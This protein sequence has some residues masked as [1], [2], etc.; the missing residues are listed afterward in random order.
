MDKSMRNR[1]RANEIEADSRMGCIQW[2]RRVSQSPADGL[3]LCVTE[4]IRILFFVLGHA[5][6][7]R[8]VSTL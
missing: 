3:S 2:N 4:T 6:A 5:S 7:I 1:E 8:S